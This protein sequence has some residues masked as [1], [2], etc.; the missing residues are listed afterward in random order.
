MAKKTKKPKDKWPGLI[1]IVR[2]D[3]GCLLAFDDSDDIIDWAGVKEITRAGI[4]SFRGT[5][6]VFANVETREV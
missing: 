2:D 6:E 3:E 5:V 4:F 1:Y